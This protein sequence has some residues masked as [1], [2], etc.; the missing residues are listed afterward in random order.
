MWTDGGLEFVNRE[1]ELQ[2]LTRCL[3]GSPALPALIFLRGPSGVGKS[4]TVRNFVCG[5]AG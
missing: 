4:G 3:A 2:F 5:R 1:K